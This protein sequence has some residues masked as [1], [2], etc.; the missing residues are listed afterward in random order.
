MRYNES[1]LLPVGGPLALTQILQRWNYAFQISGPNAAA[2]SCQCAVKRVVI[3][4]TDSPAPEP[5]NHSRAGA[6][7]PLE[8]P[9]AGISS[10]NTSTI[11]GYLRAHGRSHREMATGGVVAFGQRAFSRLP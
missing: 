9:H 6:K 4:E 7:S 2:S 5:A 11:C 8:G 3:V 1:K 10:G